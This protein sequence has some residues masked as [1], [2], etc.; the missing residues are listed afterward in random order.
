MASDTVYDAIRAH[1]AA[2]WAATPVAFENEA[3]VRPVV[4]GTP[5]PF[6][7][8][9]ITGTAYGQQSIG[10]RTQAEN[11]WDEE[12]QLWLHVFVATGSGGSTVRRYAKQLADLFRGT[13]LLADTLEFGDASIGMG[14]PGDEEGAYF[15]VSV[16]LDWR[17]IET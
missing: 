17:R 16:S 2:R 15:R 6:V 10:A 8:L 11:R 5:Q 14:E 3:F 12:G 9:E 13:T 7:V 4:D 1:L